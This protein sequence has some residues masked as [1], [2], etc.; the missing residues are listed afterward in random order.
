MKAVLP[1]DAIPVV[2]SSDDNYAYPLGVMFISLLENT[3]R[4]ERFHLFIIDGG[5]A[6]KK[7][8][9]MVDDVA[10]RGS[11]LTFLDLDSEMYADF[12][13]HAHISKPT[14]YRISIPE[15][16]DDSIKKAI[17]L[18]CDLII[19]GDLQELWD[20]DLGEYAVGAVEN[21]SQHTYRVSKLNQ[22]DY[23]NSG[24]LLIDLEK[25][26]INKLSEKVREFKLNNPEL[27]CTNDQCAFNGVFR[28]HWLRLPLK[29]NHQSGLYRESNQ[30][31]R[32]KSSGQY[33]DAIWHP[34]IIHYVGWSKP[35]LSPCYHPLAAEYDRYNS[36]A[37]FYADNPV[38]PARKSKSGLW[39]KFSLFK[40][41]WRKYRWQQRYKRQ[42]Y[43]LYEHHG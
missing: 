8:Q 37:L 40:K 41:Q 42:G 26:R 6:E 43:D 24:V 32:F 5:I 9:Q 33:Q 30:I 15:L 12:P 18:D 25:W 22:D 19:K 20:I 16:F 13:T 39:S 27:I 7:K 4:P 21:I 17:Y 1:D 3:S 34:A 11:Q 28:G 23:F 14:Y 35:W 10:S 38:I 2:A 31:N 36:L 29:W